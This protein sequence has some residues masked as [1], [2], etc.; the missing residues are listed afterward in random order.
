MKSYLYIY[1]Y[2]LFFFKKRGEK[3]KPKDFF[4][5]KNPSRELLGSGLP[6]CLWRELLSA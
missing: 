4:K 3:K 2:I 1:I 6:R 5:L